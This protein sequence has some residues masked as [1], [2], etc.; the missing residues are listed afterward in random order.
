MVI[1]HKSDGVENMHKHPW[2]L[3]FFTV[4]VAVA[5]LAMQQRTIVRK[6]DEIQ[7]LRKAIAR[8][9]A[10]AS[11]N[12]ITQHAR[13]VG[14]TISWKRAGHSL[15]ENGQAKGMR[16]LLL[17]TQLERQLLRMS[18]DELIASVAEVEAMDLPQ[19]EKTGIIHAIRNVLAQKDPQWI[20]EQAMVM[21]DGKL[22][23][24]SW[25]IEKAIASWASENPSA[26]IAW[27][28][29]EASRGAINEEIRGNGGPNVRVILESC[30]L[31]SLLGSSVDA[32]HARVAAMPDELK[33][34]VLDF[35]SRNPMITRQGNE[36][37]FGVLIQ[38]LA[39][40]DLSGK[41]IAG[42]AYNLINHESFDKLTDFMNRMD[43]TPDVR[44]ALV[45]MASNATF[46][47][48]LHYEFDVGIEQIDKLRDWAAQQAPDAVDA[49]TATALDACLMQRDGENFD[50]I[51][52]LAVH[53]HDAGASDEVLLGILNSWHT[54]GHEEMA[55]QLATKIR[56][57]V[58]RSQVIQKLQA[59]T[60]R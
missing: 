43:A 29:T 20:L 1:C 24:T 35:M 49:A 41:I 54:R 36:V 57:D 28:D 12:E 34:R 47:R 19:E 33:N 38:E 46:Q 25:P 18:A 17:Y 31:S 56:D 2:L 44:H 14:K 39:P 50:D 23:A 37:A 52:K 10:Q 15:A 4:V 32:A 8:S 45:K 5:L 42:Q 40:E 7:R 22:E 16:D 53:Y 6:T 27:L 58:A 21:V 59:T 60:P 30:L 48:R 11:Q 51:S 26:A 3:P 9:A 55:L 13:H